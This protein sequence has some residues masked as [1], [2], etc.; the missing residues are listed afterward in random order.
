MIKDFYIKLC[1]FCECWDRVNTD[2]CPGY[3]EDC[4]YNLEIEEFV[5]FDDMDII[6]LFD[7]E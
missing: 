6:D 4:E 5:K 2:G 7:S 3:C 1:K